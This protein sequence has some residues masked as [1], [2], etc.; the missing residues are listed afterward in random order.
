M[1][2]IF[3]FWRTLVYIVGQYPCFQET[4]DDDWES[5]WVKS[6]WKDSEGTAGDLRQ[7]EIER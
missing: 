6:Q 5:R 2:V 4:F 7:T 1:A 3:G